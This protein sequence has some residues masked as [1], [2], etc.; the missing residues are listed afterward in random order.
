[1]K[2]SPPIKKVRQFFV[3]KNSD[4]SEYNLNMSE[5]ISYGDFFA[6]MDVEPSTSMCII[7]TNCSAL[8]STQP[9]ILCSFSKIILDFLALSAFRLASNGELPYPMVIE[10]CRSNNLANFF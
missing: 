10:S 8:P 5:E 3:K 1:M 9:K 7:C 2:L 4:I 6:E